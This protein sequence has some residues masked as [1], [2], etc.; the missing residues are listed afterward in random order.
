MLLVEQEPNARVGMIARSVRGGWFGWY[1]VSGLVEEDESMD[2]A[3]RRH[4]QAAL[5]VDFYGDLR[6]ERPLGVV[7]HLRNPDDL[8]AP[9]QHV[10]ALAYAVTPKGEPRS[11]NPESSF[12]WF[13]LDEFPQPELCLFGQGHSL[14]EFAQ[15]AIVRERM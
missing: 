8:V 3:A 10:V 6:D 5:G 13:R 1:L 12:S 7:E 4:L 14:R 2:S 9:S 11:Q 15:L